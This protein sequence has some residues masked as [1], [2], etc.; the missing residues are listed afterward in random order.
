M[1]LTAEDFEWV[2]RALL[3]C[4]EGRAVSGTGEGGQVEVT[5]TKLPESGANTVVAQVI[6]GRGRAAKDA[7]GVG[8]DA[9][10]SPGALSSCTPERRGKLPFRHGRRG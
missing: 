1:E 10:T 8:V 4:C 6:G 3:R 9:A 5:G 7:G 2:T